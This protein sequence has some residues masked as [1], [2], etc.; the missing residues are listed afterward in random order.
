MVNMT[1]NSHNGRT[2]WQDDLVFG[3]WPAFEV[4]CLAGINDWLV[5]V[6]HCNE[7]C[8]FCVEHVIHVDILE[9]EFL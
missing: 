2:L 8:I 4:S 7:A 9:T 3:R 1:H 5:V 6:F